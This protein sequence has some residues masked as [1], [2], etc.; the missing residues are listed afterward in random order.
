M[1]LEA[2]GVFAEVTAH[3]LHL[4]HHQA[5][6]V[7]QGVACRGRSDTP[8]GSLEQG[9]ANLV[10]HPTHAR[11]GGC[12]GEPGPGATLGDAARFGDQQKQPQVGEVEMHQQPPWAT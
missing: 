2:V 9:D 7:Q 12:Q 6:M 5:G 10:L 8:A 11:T 4:L 3:P 1:A